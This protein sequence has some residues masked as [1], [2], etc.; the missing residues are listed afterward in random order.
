[1]TSVLLRSCSVVAPCF[2]RVIVGQTSEQLRSKFG[3]I[4]DLSYSGS[5]QTFVWNVREKPT[6][7]IYP[8]MKSGSTFQQH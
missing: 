5:V 2:V 1:S 3:E 6:T 8:I 4:Q 7:T